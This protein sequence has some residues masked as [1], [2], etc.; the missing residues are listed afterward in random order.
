MSQYPPVTVSDNRCNS[1]TDL[2]QAHSVKFSLDS[3]LN[4]ALCPENLGRSRWVAFLRA[5]TSHILFVRGK[6]ICHGH[7][8]FNTSYIHCPAHW[9]RGG[10]GAAVTA[11]VGKTPVAQRASQR[12]KQLKISAK[13]RKIERKAERQENNF[14]KKNVKIQLATSR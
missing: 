14:D 7:K 4:I 5:K 3:N 6:H 8:T 2:S 11:M 1:Y 13:D 10:G 9:R 12:P